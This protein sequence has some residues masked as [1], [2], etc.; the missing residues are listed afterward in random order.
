MG[1]GIQ[2]S[3]GL[4]TWGIH[5]E[6]SKHF[7]GSLQSLW[8]GVSTCVAASELDQETD[9]QRSIPPSKLVTFYGNISLIQVALWLQPAILI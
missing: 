6:A 7:K 1:Q 4:G 9:L 3:L 2:Y 5:S 8:S